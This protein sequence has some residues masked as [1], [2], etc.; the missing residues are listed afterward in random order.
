M[1]KSSEEIVEYIK[2]LE[3][4]G[5]TPFKYISEDVFKNFTHFE[6]KEF[7]WKSDFIQWN[8]VWGYEVYHK[9]RI[10]KHIKNEED[11]NKYYKLYERDMPPV[12]LDHRGYPLDGYHRLARLKFEKSTSFMAYVGVRRK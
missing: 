3:R 12:V 11:R 6:L 9:K 5:D 8:S 7:E 2:K 1:N 4:V 10:D